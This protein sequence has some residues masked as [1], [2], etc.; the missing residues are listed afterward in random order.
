MDGMLPLHWVETLCRRALSLLC[1]QV[2]TRKP[3]SYQ[4][5][6]N[7]NSEGALQAINILSA[8]PRLMRD[9]SALTSSTS[10]TP[11]SASS[12]TLRSRSPSTQAATASTLS[13]RLLR[14]YLKRHV[15]YRLR[16]CC[17]EVQY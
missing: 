6:H 15:R 4:A 13:G 14:C 7:R 3:C 2:L 1:V 10:H 12:P 16:T 17:D 11:G 8:P 9:A 5:M